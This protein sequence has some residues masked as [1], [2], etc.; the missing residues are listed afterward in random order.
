MNSVRTFAVSVVSRLKTVVR[1][2]NNGMPMVLIDA[3][4]VEPRPARA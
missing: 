1:L 3:G 4:S 2:V